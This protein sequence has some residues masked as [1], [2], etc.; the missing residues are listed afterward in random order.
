MAPAKELPAACL[1]LRTHRLNRALHGPGGTV[2]PRHRRPVRRR[3]GTGVV[4]R[5]KARIDRVPDANV[6]YRTFQG[7]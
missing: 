5:A 1:P 3:R 7:L 4:P 6:A 2:R